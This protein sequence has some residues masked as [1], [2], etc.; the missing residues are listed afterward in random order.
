M[1]PL[2]GLQATTWYK[3]LAVV[4]VPAFIIALLA[5]RDPLMAIFGGAF[6]I[7]VGEWRYYAGKRDQFPPDP[8]WR[9]QGY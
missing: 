8:R 3:A 7:A 2:E 1:N 9:G 6:L 4:A 5:G